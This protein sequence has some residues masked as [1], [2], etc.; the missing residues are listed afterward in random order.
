M[1]LFGSMREASSPVNSV[2]MHACM[3]G[4]AGR[5]AAF[6]AAAPMAPRMR[7]CVLAGRRYPHNYPVQPVA[8][9]LKQPRG[10]TEAQLAALSEEL[11]A[12]AAAHAAAS[13]V[14]VFDLVTQVMDS[15]QVGRRATRPHQRSSQSARSPGQ[16]FP[17]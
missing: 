1:R 7:A 15:L 4:P 9:K 11:A 5:A 12:G 2:G 10:F 16:A 3:C 8:L 17:A 14:C 6:A 13:Q